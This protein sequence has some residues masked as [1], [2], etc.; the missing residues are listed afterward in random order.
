MLYLN[1]LAPPAGL[2]LEAPFKNISTAAKDYIIAPLFL[3]NR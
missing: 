3:N 2:I 1:D